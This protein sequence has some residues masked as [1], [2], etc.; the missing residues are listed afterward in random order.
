[1]SPVFLEV[2][3]VLEIHHHQIE[4]YGGANGVRDMGLLQSAVAAPR[5]TFGGQ[6]LNQDL[7]EMAAAYLFHI[8]QN[9]PFIDGNKRSGAMAAFVFLR[10]NGI[11][12]DAPEDEFEETVLEIA[13]TEAD[14]QDAARFFRKFSR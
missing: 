13:R 14:K 12:L 1:M 9:H 11:K 8:V 4:K 10:I 5:A 7:F 3:D 2:G 6:F